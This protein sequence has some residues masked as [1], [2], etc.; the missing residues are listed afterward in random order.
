MGIIGMLGM[1]GMALAAVA[2]GGT[3]LWSSYRAVREE[4]IA[5][6]LRSQPPGP[7]GLALVIVGM[8]LPTVMITLFL[9]ALAGWLVGLVVGA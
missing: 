3:V 1:L 4:L 5:R 7:G 8:L 2:A 6:N 9:L